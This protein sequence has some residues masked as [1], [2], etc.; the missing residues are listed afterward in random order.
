MRGG[1]TGRGEVVRASWQAGRNHVFKA[2][3]GFFLGWKSNHKRDSGQFGRSRFS[4]KLT[5][6]FVFR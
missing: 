2:V 6:I 5:D 3:S 4:F 1:S